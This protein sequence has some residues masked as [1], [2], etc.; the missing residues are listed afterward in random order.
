M[1][2][3][4]GWLSENTSVSSLLLLLLS[5]APRGLS[6]SLGLTLLL[7]CRNG[8]LRRDSWLIARLHVPRF[9]AGS[10]HRVRLLLHG[11]HVAVISVRP[12]SLVHL[13][14]A[15]SL[16]TGHQAGVAGCT[17]SGR[18]WGSSLAHGLSCSR[19]CATTASGEIV[20]HSDANIDVSTLVVVVSAELELN[21]L[22]DLELNVVA[23]VR[24]LA[25]LEILMGVLVLAMT[26]QVTV[27]F[28]IR[29]V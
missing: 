14:V 5:L 4:R 26:D 9:L 18:V 20:W 7:R 1:R 12:L 19:R 11:S 8:H 29:L 23:V 3:T 10:T 22:V 27:V 16:V 28:V 21:I 13:V 17:T 15:S 2:Q 24:F 6:I 25:E